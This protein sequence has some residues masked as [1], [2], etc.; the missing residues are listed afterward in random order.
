V[1]GI[2]GLYTKKYSQEDRDILINTL[3]VNERRGGDSVGLFLYDFQSQYKNNIYTLGR[4]SKP[5]ISS[6]HKSFKKMEGREVILLGH[7]RLTATGSHKDYHPATFYSKKYMVHNGVMTSKLFNGGINDTYEAIRIFEE[8]G[9][10]SKLKDKIFC[11]G[12]AWLIFDTDR[13]VLSVGKMGYNPLEVLYKPNSVFMASTGLLK[14]GA[15]ELTDIDNHFY[16]LNRDDISFK[17]VKPY[18]GEDFCYNK[19]SDGGISYSKDY[20]NLYESDKNKGLT[21]DGVDKKAIPCFNPNTGCYQCWKCG[22][23]DKKQYIYGCLYCEECNKCI[24]GV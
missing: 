9:I 18:I 20:K 17:S 1:C 10:S 13:E 2:I 14:F 8:D 7:T 15:F 22:E 12:S 3:R 5:I 23:C 19:Y 11:T 4:S 16:K 21:K 6:I 24:D